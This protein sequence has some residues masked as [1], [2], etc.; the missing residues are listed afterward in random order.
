M[1]GMLEDVGMTL[2]ASRSQIDA[3]GDRLRKGDPR[4]GDEELLEA[5][6]RKHDAALASVVEV[7]RTVELNDGSAAV[8]NSR[9]KTR[10]TLVEKLVREKSRLSAVQ[11]VAG[12]RILVGPSLDTQDRVAAAVAS[13][14]SE[15]RVIDRRADPRSGYRAVHVVVRHDECFVEVQVRTELQ[16]LWAEA[17]ERLADRVGR[18]IRYGEPPPETSGGEPAGRLVH[19]LLDFSGDVDHL[20]RADRT[21]A[22]LAARTDALGPAP[23]P[24]QTMWG[25]LWGRLRPDPDAEAAVSL[26]EL[27]DSLLNLRDLMTAGLTDLRATL[28]DK[29]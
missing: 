11:D 16:H 28:H 18:Q 21:Y 7:L 1:C 29:R 27:S 14:F 26:A 23:K 22:E 13:K 19:E 3:L 5:W 6:L 10:G 25:R 2:P 9:V 20:E 4:P 15:S 17:F 24:P 12:A 8:P